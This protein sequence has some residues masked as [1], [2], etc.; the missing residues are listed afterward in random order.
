MPNSPNDATPSRRAA[1]TAI[2]TFEAPAMAWSTVMTLSRRR[3]DCFES[4]TG[5]P[6][7]DRPGVSLRVNDASGPSDTGRSRPV[8][9]RRLRQGLVVTLAVG[10]IFAVEV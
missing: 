1:S 8:D 2:R 4:F 7:V 3:A 10:E 9:A 6:G 5:F